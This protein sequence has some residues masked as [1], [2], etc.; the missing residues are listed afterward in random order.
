MSEVTPSIVEDVKAIINLVKEANKA[1]V[2]LN[3]HPA[4]AKVVE[5]GDMLDAFVNKQGKPQ[6]T[7][8]GVKRTRRTPAQI[9]ADK[10]A[11]GVQ[12]GKA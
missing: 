10:A 12:D 7:K 11:K 9:A 8:E 3:N 2:A 5:F 6:A 1:M 4:L